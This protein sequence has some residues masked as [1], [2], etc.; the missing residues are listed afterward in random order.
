MYQFTANA[1]VYE[2]KFNNNIEKAS[3]IKTTIFGEQEQRVREEEGENHYTERSRPPR[4]VNM[5]F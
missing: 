4:I 3:I 1:V 5:S 2:Y